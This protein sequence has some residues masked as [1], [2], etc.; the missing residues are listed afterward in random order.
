[1][2][3]YTDLLR[4]MNCLI[5]ALAIAVGAAVAVGFGSLGGSAT[6]VMAA[7]VT[8]FLFTGAGNALNDYYDREV[9]RIN[10]PARPIPSGRISARSALNLAWILFVA[11]L[12]LGIVVGLLAFLIVAV[13]LVAMVSYEVRFKRRGS[14]GNLIISWLVASLFL[15]GGVASYGESAVALE[16][17]SWLALLAFLPTLGREIVKDIED[18]AGD[19]DRKTLPMVIGIERAG[20]IASTAF[21]I[22]VA[23]SPMPYMTGVLGAPYLGIVTLADGIFIYC[24]WFSTAKPSMVS[25]GAK[26]GMFVAL[27]AF[28]AGGAL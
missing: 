2:R 12:I 3:G 8:G 6:R 27:I 21:I 9:D 10:H 20:F 23:L 18:I 13:N 16:R 26:Y 1:M 19:V 25:K 5:A 14:S 22:G 15:F 11:A 17:V 7:A 4:P 28:L 24:A